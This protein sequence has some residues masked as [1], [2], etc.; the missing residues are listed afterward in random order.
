MTC[1]RSY[2]PA[3]TLVTARQNSP[4]FQQLLDGYLTD[5]LSDLGSDEDWPTTDTEDE[6]SEKGESSD[7]SE[8]AEDPYRGRQR[9]RTRG[10]EV[11][12]GGVR[13]VR[14]GS[15]K[16]SICEVGLV[17]NAFHP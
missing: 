12:T 2:L 8:Q 1:F 10:G 11:V 7:N 6:S 3:L 15:C 17:F 13:R 16:K 4:D 14:R 5:D 9:K